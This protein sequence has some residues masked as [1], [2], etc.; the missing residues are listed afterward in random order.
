MENTKLICEYCKKTLIPFKTRKDWINRKYHLKCWQEKFD[1]FVRQEAM[2]NFLK[3]QS[4]SN[5]ECMK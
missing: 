2:A 4:N 1:E 5:V 3:E